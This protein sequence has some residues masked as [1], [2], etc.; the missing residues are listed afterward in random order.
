MAALELFQLTPLAEETISS[1]IGERSTF[2]VKGFLFCDIREMAHVTKFPGPHASPSELPSGAP[3]ARV[4]SC[5][6]ESR[7]S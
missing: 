1:F 3:H 7:P 6:S 2:R 5:V 4:S